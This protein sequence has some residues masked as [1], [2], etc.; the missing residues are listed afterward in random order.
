MQQEPT[1]PEDHFGASVATHLEFQ[2][3]SQRKFAELLTENGM[4]VDASAVSRLLKGQRAMR[5]SEVYVVADTLGVPL[6]QLL[7][8]LVRPKDGLNMARSLADRAWLSMGGQA[9]ALI[10]AM[11][12]IVKRLES[13]PSL[14]E[15]IVDEDGHTLDKPENYFEWV[16]AR[17][18]RSLDVRVERGQVS[19]DGLLFAATAEKKAQYLDVIA[20]LIEPFVAVGVHPDLRD[21]AEWRQGPP[22]GMPEPEETDG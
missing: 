8:A 17:A 22:E 12:D 16:A 18:G 5:L 10:Q 4:P 3:L 2:G 14:L 13:D 20:R 19:L 6:D 11:E 7:P 21:D 1:S 9:G 15:M